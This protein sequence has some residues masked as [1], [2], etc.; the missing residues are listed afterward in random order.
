MNK[1]DYTTLV[2]IE[3]AIMKLDRIFRKVSQFHNR[4]FLDNKNHTRRETRM[5]DRKKERWDNNY[6]FYYGELTEEEQ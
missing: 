5:N 2:D 6:S 3:K 4:S 1:V